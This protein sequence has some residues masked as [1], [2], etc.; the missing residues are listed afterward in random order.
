MTDRTV[1][2]VELPEVKEFSGEKIFET[3]SP[4][5]FK[6]ITLEVKVELGSTIIALDRLMSLT[7]GS[8]LELDTPSN[9]NVCLKVGEEIFAKGRL[10]VVDG[11]YGVEVEEKFSIS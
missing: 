2:I 10:V 4:R 7:V 1:E 5:F 6:G 11:F 9:Q 3:I 8:V